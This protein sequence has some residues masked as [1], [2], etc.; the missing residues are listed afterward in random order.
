MFSLPHF[1]VPATGSQ[2]PPDS[3]RSS[4]KPLRWLAAPFVARMDRSEIRN[5]RVGTDRYRSRHPGY[6]AWLRTGAGASSNHLRQEGSVKSPTVRVMAA[7]DEDPAIQT[8]VLAFATDP[9]AR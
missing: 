1:D 5:R 3:P 8:V 6:D 2:A 7:A 9:M 4:P